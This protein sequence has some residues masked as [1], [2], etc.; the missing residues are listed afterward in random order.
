MSYAEDC[1]TQL[2]WVNKHVQYYT[3][4]R[5][6]S[7]EYF[8]HDVLFRIDGTSATQYQVSANNE[9]DAIK[10]VIPIANAYFEAQKQV[11]EEE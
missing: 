1:Q 3:S 7:G 4:F 6:K 9:C 11:E 5:T 10:K 2:E 8:S